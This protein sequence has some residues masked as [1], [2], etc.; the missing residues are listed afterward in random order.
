M[1]NCERGVIMN[2]LIACEES[3][4]VCKAFRKRGANA[5]SCDL[6]NCSGN[7]PEWHIK[8]NVIPLLGGG[9]FTTQDGKTHTVKKWD[10]IISHPPCTYLTITGN[11]WFDVKKYGDKAIK[12]YGERE[13]AINFFLEFAKAD[14]ECIAI[15]NPIGCMSKIYKEPTQIIQPY[16]FGD[17]ERKATCLWLKGCAN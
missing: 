2:V 15:E 5:F 11:R 6:V 10:I 14:C 13:Q 7:K 17:R 4:T 1:T 12:R 9:D 8:G 3:Q 16:Q